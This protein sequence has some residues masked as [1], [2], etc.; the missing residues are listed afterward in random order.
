[1]KILNLPKQLDVVL[2]CKGCSHIYVYPYSTPCCIDLAKKI[3]NKAMDLAVKMNSEHWH[4][5]S[6]DSTIGLYVR[7]LN[8]KFKKEKL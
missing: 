6:N 5:D 2:D 3:W 8:E 7:D 4:L 1:M